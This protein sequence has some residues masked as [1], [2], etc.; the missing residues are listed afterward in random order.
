MAGSKAVMKNTIAISRPTTVGSPAGARKRPKDSSASS[1]LEATKMPPIEIRFYGDVPQKVLD[2]IHERH[3]FWILENG[4]E[5]GQKWV[6]VSTTPEYIEFGAR[7]TAGSWIRGFRNG[8]A[9]TQKQLGARLGGVSPSRISDWERDRRPVSKAF[10]RK[11]AKVFSV[12]A[13]LFI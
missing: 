5:A 10:A 1:T 6:D 4:E 9:L 11:L 13:D 3:E 7:Q 8:I 12:G 2:D